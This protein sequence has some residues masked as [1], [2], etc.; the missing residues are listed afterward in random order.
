MKAS[1]RRDEMPCMHKKKSVSSAFKIQKEKEKNGREYELSGNSN[2]SIKNNNVFMNC[3]TASR[4]K[5]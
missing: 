3:T 1:Q 4:S 2:N 5:R